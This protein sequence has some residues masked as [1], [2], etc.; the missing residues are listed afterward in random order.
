MERDAAGE[1]A[2]IRAAVFDAR[3]RREYE[4]ELLRAKDRAQDS[5]ARARAL[6]R[7]LQETLIPPTPPQV[8]DLDVGAVYRP[9]G[10]GEEVGG[11]F[12]DVFQVGEDDWVVAIGD[13]CGKGVD[14]AVLTA[15]VRYA[16]RGAAVRQQRPGDMLTDV[17]EVLI[18][19]SSE[20]FCTVAVLRLRRSEG[21]W[22][23]S[24]A[25]G[26][27]PAPMLRREG[28]PVSI[29]A[30]TGPLLGVLEDVVYPNL[31]VSLRTEDLL[32]LYTDGV[33]EG[34]R[35]QEF[36][37]E[38]RMQDVLARDLKTADDV[39]AALLADVLEFQD[40]VTR[41]DIAVVA[42]RVPPG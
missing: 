18:R 39:T 8:P 26:G 20:R 12:Y 34:R 17:N 23:A 15:L 30:A 28:E 22:T 35:G 36:Y 1:P 25:A 7:T 16:L 31:D 24:V 5:E 19:D 29:L 9:A 14:A 3:D 32:L 4:R 21:E 13:V 11:D 27:H 41:D 10:N 37:G 38:E 42:V 6:A 40:G 2:V 33:P